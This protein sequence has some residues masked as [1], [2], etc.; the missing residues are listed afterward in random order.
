MVR[1]FS[2]ISATARSCYSRTVGVNN[3]IC[4]PRRPPWWFERWWQRELARHRRLWLPNSTK[5]CK[6]ASRR[7][8][9]CY[10]FHWLSCYTGSGNCNFCKC[11]DV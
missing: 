2:S 5:R 9:R 3:R 11:P 10:S 1:V 6:T 4:P 8:G 7:T